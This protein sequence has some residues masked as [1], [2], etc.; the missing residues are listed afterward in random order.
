MTLK[1]NAP[2]TYITSYGPLILFFV[3]VFIV[4]GHQ[5]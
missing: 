1:L 3:V 4:F 2:I 5:K